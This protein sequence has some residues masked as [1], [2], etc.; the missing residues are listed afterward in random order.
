MQHLP[1]GPATPSPWTH[2]YSH[3]IGSILP[4]LQRPPS[5]ALF[6]CLWRKYSLSYWTAI[7][8]SFYPSWL[9]STLSSV[10]LVSP[11]YYMLICVPWDKAG[12]TFRPSRDPAQHLIMCPQFT[13]NQSS[14]PISLT[15]I[16]LSFSSV[17]SS[18]PTYSF[19]ICVKVLRHRVMGIKGKKKEE[20]VEV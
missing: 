11:L 6:L 12:F 19:S 9:F 8:P 18:Q 4:V 7:A 15:L 5:P 16:F 1:F 10:I 20:K 13:L 3:F 14:L 17:L 2:P